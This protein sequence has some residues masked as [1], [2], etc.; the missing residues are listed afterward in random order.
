MPDAKG[1]TTFLLHPA[2]ICTPPGTNRTC[3]M[4][5]TKRGMTMAS[6]RLS[7][8]LG[9]HPVMKA[10]MKDCKLLPWSRPSQYHSQ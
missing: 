4:R 8:R 2:C 5:Y 6:H 7:S 3:T 10:R 1:L 9:S